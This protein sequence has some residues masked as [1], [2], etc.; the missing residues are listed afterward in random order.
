MVP[1]TSTLTRLKKT[2]SRSNKSAGT[3]N[4]L[5]RM[6]LRDGPSAAGRPSSCAAAGTA[7]AAPNAATSASAARFP[8]AMAQARRIPLPTDS[9]L[10]FAP[11][12]TRVALDE[13]GR[14]DENGAAIRLQLSSVKFSARGSLDASPMLLERLHTGFLCWGKIGLQHFQRQSADTA[15]NTPMPIIHVEVNNV[16]R[17]MMVPRVACGHQR[18]G[19]L[20]SNRG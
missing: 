18:H 10:L 5:V 4:R 15:T 12:R 2:A 11:L 8:F 9:K 3:R 17:E 13:I 16:A 19:S 1:P 20:F 14:P 6:T 7:S